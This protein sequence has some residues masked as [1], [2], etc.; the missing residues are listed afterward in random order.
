[1]QEGKRGLKQINYKQIKYLQ[2]NNGLRQGIT[3]IIG[4]D[5]SEEVIFN[6]Y[7]EDETTPTMTGQEVES[8]Q[9]RG[10]QTHKESEMGKN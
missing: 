6:Y 4:N 9:S 8:I 10:N 3:W 1:M 7:L 2:I 5:R